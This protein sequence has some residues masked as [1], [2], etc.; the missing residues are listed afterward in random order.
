MAPL[1]LIAGDLANLTT[2][3]IPAG[4]KA[5]APS[6]FMFR[7]IAIGDYAIACLGFERAQAAGIGHQ[8]PRRTE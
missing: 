3:K 4:H 6:A 2:G 1:N 5:D 7:G 8:V